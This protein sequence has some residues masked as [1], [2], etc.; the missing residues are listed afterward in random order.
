MEHAMKLLLLLS[1]LF[2]LAACDH[3]TPCDPGQT[4]AHGVCYAPPD[5]G[6]ATADASS[7]TIVTGRH[8]RGTFDENAATDRADVHAPR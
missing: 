7:A 6:P 5:A 1:M 3:D 4:Y 8:W 2:A